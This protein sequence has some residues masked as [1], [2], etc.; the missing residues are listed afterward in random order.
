MKSSL[1]SY[2]WFEDEKEKKSKSSVFTLGL[3]VH[4]FL[5]EP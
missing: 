1:Y 2:E 3:A 5:R 4:S